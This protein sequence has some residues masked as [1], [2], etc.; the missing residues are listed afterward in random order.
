MYKAVPVGAGVGQV[1]PSEVEGKIPG[2][3]IFEPLFLKVFGGPQNKGL[4]QPKQRYFWV[5]E[6]L[7]NIFI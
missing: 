5:V 1:A 4:F 2:A 6:K 7:P 3:P